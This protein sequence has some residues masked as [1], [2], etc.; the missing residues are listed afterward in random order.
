MIKTID[1][2]PKHL[3]IIRGILTKHL[4]ANTIVYAFGSRAT[5]KAK[6]FSDLDLAI[7]TMN[8]HI[9]PKTMAL[10]MTDFEFS[11]LPYKVDIVDWTAIDESFRARIFG[12]IVEIDLE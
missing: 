2:E 4:P 3:K 1:V 7:N 6:K 9:P 10:L 11:S 5:M 8:Q 12:D